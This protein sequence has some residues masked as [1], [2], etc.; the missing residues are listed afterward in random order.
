MPW[1]GRKRI[2]DVLRARRLNRKMG[3]G[4]LLVRERRR[5][6]PSNL[7]ENR[8]PD[9]P[10]WYPHNQRSKMNGQRY[11]GWEFSREWRRPIRNRRLA[12]GILVKAET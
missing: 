2:D 6:P 3:E 11:A 8:R 4:G 1:D 10:L 7:A 9:P 12:R 5:R